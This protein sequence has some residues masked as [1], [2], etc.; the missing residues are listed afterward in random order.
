MACVQ[1]GRQALRYAFVAYACLMKRFQFSLRSMFWYTLVVA[2]GFSVSVP[3]QLPFKWRL[4][5]RVIALYGV[6]AISTLVLRYVRLIQAMRSYAAQQP[7][8]S[9]KGPSAGEWL[10]G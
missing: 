2:A 4:L 10:E 6:F 5:F 8:L 1:C 9:G 3:A 7:A